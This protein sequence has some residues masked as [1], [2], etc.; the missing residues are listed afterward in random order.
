MN[1][2][3]SLAWKMNKNLIKSLKCVRTHGNDHDTWLFSLGRT[4]M[5]AYQPKFNQK[6]NE[7]NF[8]YFD[9]TISLP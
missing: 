6:L 1:Y 9:K 5:P 2:F 3:Q 4:S 7:Y 8:N